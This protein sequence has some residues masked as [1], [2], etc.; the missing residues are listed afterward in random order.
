MTT[1]EEL[2]RILIRILEGDDEAELFEF[3]EEIESDG[4]EESDE[5]STIEQYLEVLEE[6][7]EDSESEN[8]HTVLLFLETERG[9]TI[10]QYNGDRY[11]KAHGFKDKTRWTCS[12][13]Q[14]NAYVDLSDK[15]DI[16]M[17][18]QRHDHKKHKQLQ[19]IYPNENDSAVVITSRKGKEMLLFRKYT[20]RKQYNKGT[21][22][23][24]VCSTMKNCRGCVFT[25]NDNFITSAFEEHC[26]DP[27]KYYL[28][29]NHVLGALREPLV[30]ES[31]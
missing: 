24:W 9:E 16:L 26:H 3:V 5:T 21:R 4:P 13:K 17:M 20:Y 18:N 28:N 14:C 10:L 8:D 7:A 27:P 30:L 29:P 2:I 19:D 25:N 22:S 6:Y 11:H 31:D 12:V 1:T 15:N 23:R